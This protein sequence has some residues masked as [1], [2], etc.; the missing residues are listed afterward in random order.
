MSVVTNDGKSHA[1]I[2][3]KAMKK[4][5]P[6]VHAES[7]DPNAA[8]EAAAS[9]M[10]QKAQ[11]AARLARAK[12][13]PNELEI[14]THGGN[15]HTMTDIFGNILPVVYIA[16]QPCPLNEKRCWKVELRQ[17]RTTSISFLSTL[18]TQSSSI[19]HQQNFDNGWNRANEWTRTAKA[20]NQGSPI[21]RENGN[22][23]IA[24]YV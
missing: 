17:R 13:A 23:D 16:N 3:R 8:E 11:K 24:N 19:N 6:A 10:A 15:Y 12:Y 2:N 14:A 20:G 21:T 1:S 18:T 7:I 22:G 9:I 5:D 4:M